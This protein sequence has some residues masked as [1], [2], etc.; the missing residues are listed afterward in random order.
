[1][2]KYFRSN[3]RKGYRRFA[4][5]KVAGKRRTG[6]SARVKRYV[7]KE[8]HRNIENKS[9]ITY[10]ANQSLTVGSGTTQSLPLLIGATQGNDAQ[11]RIGNQIKI[12]RGC[13]RMV[14]NLLPWNATTNPNPPPVWVKLWVVRDLKNTGQLSS[15]D[16]TAFGK[17]FRIGNS[18]LGFQGTPIDM[19]FD[20]NKD[21]FRVLTTKTFRL[22]AASAYMSNIPVSQYAYYDNSSASKQII[23]NYA[24]WCKKQLKFD[25]NN[26]QWP[27]NENLYIIMQTTACDGTQNG[28]NNALVEYHYVNTC[29]YE[30]A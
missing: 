14:F 13:I 10:A 20:V 4:R 7:K 21:Y 3:R 16:S 12:T 19:C 26:S 28:L 11:T 27:I 17:F 30:D 1:M 6:V 8:L 15:I 25:D 22:G 5:R 24:K 2:A 9:R 18:S 23:F 29:E